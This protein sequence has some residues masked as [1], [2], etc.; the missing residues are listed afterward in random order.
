MFALYYKIIFML[1]IHFQQIT[2]DLVD[3][4]TKLQSSIIVQ[5]GVL[6]TPV[7][8]HQLGL[9]PTLVC[10]RSICDTRIIINV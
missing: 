7:E 5:Q 8:L 10:M 1:K 3:S 9:D 4:L 2:A 6:V